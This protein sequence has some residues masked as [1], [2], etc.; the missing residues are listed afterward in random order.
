MVRTPLKQDVEEIAASVRDA[1][2]MARHVIVSLHCHEANPVD[3]TAPPDFFVTFAHAVIDAG[4]SVVVGQGPHVLHGIEI[5]KGKPIF[6]SL[7][8]FIMQNDTV[9]RQPQENYD[10]QGLDSMARVGEF[11]LKRTAGDT[12]SYPSY[13][14]PWESVIAQPKFRD[15]QLI[16]ISLVPITLGFGNPPGLRGRPLLASAENAG[17]IL[18]DLIKMSAPLGT[19]I[20]NRN[21][22]GY[23]VLAR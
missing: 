19:K 8:D 6:Y 20:E 15:D 5:Y 14:E 3:R 17:K 13:R 1:R 10:S 21:G 12:R 4:A 11:N 7:G 23:V 2:T 9:L 22:V 16:E 18:G